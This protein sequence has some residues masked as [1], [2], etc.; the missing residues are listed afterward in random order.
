[1]GDYLVYVV[2]AYG[3]SGLALAGLGLWVF[4]DARAARARLASL[5]EMGVRRRSSAR[6]REGAA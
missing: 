5:E 3:F 4:L 6:P 1:M 2:S